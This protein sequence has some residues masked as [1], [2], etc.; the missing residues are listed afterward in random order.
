MIIASVAI[1]IGGEDD[2]ALHL[3]LH[4]LDLFLHLANLA[5]LLKQQT[6]TLCIAVVTGHRDVVAQAVLAARTYGTS[7]TLRSGIQ[8][9]ETK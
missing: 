2:S 5:I 1:A 8:Y 3:L 6:F 9:C 7:K 4:F